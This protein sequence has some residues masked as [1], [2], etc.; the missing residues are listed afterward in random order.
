[1]PEGFWSLDASLI[2]LKYGSVNLRVGTGA[3][4][5]TKTHALCIKKGGLIQTTFSTQSV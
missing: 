2:L 4:A 5:L 1:M 3:W